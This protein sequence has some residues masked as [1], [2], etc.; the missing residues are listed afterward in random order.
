MQIAVEERRKLKAMA[1]AK[2]EVELFCT[3]KWQPVDLVR[4]ATRI[5]Q[6][7]SKLPPELQIPGAKQ[8][9]STTK[10]QHYLCRYD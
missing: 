5:K 6:L 9:L 2:A 7:E 4:L 3:D 8:S 10:H 1:E